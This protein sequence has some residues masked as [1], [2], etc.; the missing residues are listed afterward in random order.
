MK[1]RYK[2]MENSKQKVLDVTDRLYDLNYNYGNKSSR[3]KSSLK[4]VYDTNLNSIKQEKY[5]RSSKNDPLDIDYAM[6]MINYKS[7]KNDPLDINHQVNEANRFMNNILSV[8]KAAELMG[9]DV[10]KISGM[11]SMSYMYQ[12]FQQLGIGSSNTSVKKVNIEVK[13]VIRDVPKIN[14]IFNP[15]VQQ[16]LR[17]EEPRQEEPRREKP[18]WEGEERRGEERW[19]D[20]EETQWEGEQE[21]P[22]LGEVPRLE[23]E[24]ETQWE[25]EQEVPRLGE[26]DREEPSTVVNTYLEIIRE[27]HTNIN[28]QVINANNALEIIGRIVT[29]LFKSLTLTI[30]A[31]NIPNTFNDDV[32]K[33]EK[34]V[35]D[36]YNKIVNALNEV[37]T[38]FTTVEHAQLIIRRL[39][40][41]HNLPNESITTIEGLILTINVAQETVNKAF[42]TASDYLA[43]VNYIKTI[44]KANIEADDA[45]NKISNTNLQFI[46]SVEIILNMFTELNNHF[47]KALAAIDDAVNNPTDETAVT[48]VSSVGLLTT[49]ETAFLSL[50]DDAD[51]LITDIESFKAIVYSAYDEVHTNC[52]HI[53]N[54][55]SIVEPLKLDKN[56]G[57]IL[58]NINKKNNILNNTSILQIIKFVTTFV[59]YIIN[60]I[61]EVLT[62]ASLDTRIAFVKFQASLDASNKENAAFNDYKV[63][64]NTAYNNYKGAINLTA[65]LAVDAAAAAAAAAAAVNAASPD[66][67]AAAAALAAANVFIAA[68]NSLAAAAYAYA[69]AVEANEDASAAASAYA[70]AASAYKD[71]YADA[72]AAYAAADTLAAINALADI[73]ALANAEPYIIYS[74]ANVVAASAYANAAAFAVD[75]DASAAAD[76]VANASAFTANAVAAINALAANINASAD[77][78]TLAAAASAY[79]A[80]VDT[81][82]EAAAAS[83]YAADVATA[84][85]AAAT[86]DVSAAA[87]D[88]N[89]AYANIKTAAD[90]FTADVDAVDAALAVAANVLAAVSTAASYAL[91]AIANEALTAA[92]DASAKAS[93]AN[94]AASTASTNVSA[95]AIASLEA[96]QEALADAVDATTNAS[97]TSAAAAE[98]AAA[99][100][101]TLTSAASA[102]SAAEAA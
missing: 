22:R 84:A 30:N 45:Y 15:I 72:A 46:P 48:A 33:V 80:A 6:R 79:A 94:A 34:Q 23:G 41:T 73:N 59:K 2:N 39:V 96:Y 57:V 31:G 86:G 18:R 20:G 63:A 101:V 82:A 10:K 42:R 7:T 54:M 3:K 68:A 92:I 64:V 40:A 17:R 91:A 32:T 100:S 87:A 81:Y 99:A 14:Q 70:A 26:G 78:N 49:T 93:L 102:A 29:D 12:M 16:P 38:A 37:N 58:A 89:V 90:V 83:A 53:H 35:V 66:A 27:A 69:V 36:F 11:E 50:V 9:M 76:A 97:K 5:K 1:N 56:I 61:K 55:G 28:K 77:A 43:L 8:N 47:E 19:E 67:A 21:E 74:A 85:E 62:T 60:I 52:T 88:V 13:P 44:I 95:A 25:G 24:E 4:T 98:A 71:A 51:R 75:A 65:E